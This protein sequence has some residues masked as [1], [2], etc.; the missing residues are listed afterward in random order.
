MVYVVLSRQSTL[1][2]G[3]VLDLSLLDDAG[4]ISLSSNHWSDSRDA[5]FTDYHNGLWEVCAFQPDDSYCANWSDQIPIINESQ[6][7]RLNGIRT[8]MV[9]ALILSFVGI[10]CE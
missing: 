4:V 9:I 1:L 7:Q 6:W 8:L 5:T 2:G 10:A 3:K